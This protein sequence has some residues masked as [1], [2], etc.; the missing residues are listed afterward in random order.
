MGGLGNACRGGRSPPLLI[1]ALIACV[2]V[3]GFNYWVSSAHNLELQKR[4]YEM[5]GA[6]RRAAVERGAVEQKKNDFQEELRRQSDQIDRMETMHKSQLENTLA[7]WKQEKATLLFNISSNSR[8]ILSMKAQFSSLFAS[9]GKIQKELQ[10]CQTNQTK[11]SSDMTQ[12]KAQ[13]V[14]LKKECAEEAVAKLEKIPPVT[15]PSQANAAPTPSSGLGKDG[16][17]KLSQ[18]DTKKPS[19]LASKTGPVAT[20]PDDP[21]AKLPML[22]TNEIAVARDG[23]APPSLTGK[24]LTKLEHSV[25]VATRK[26][27]TLQQEGGKGGAKLRE[28]LEVLD[29]HGGVLQ[30]EGKGQNPG[31]EYN[32]GEQ[33]VGESKAKKTAQL[34]DGTGKGQGLGQAEQDLEDDIADYNGD[35]ENVGE[36]EA[37]K[38]AELAKI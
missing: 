29:T 5:E 2:I 36:F 17:E 9:L 37:D 28:E 35:E 12:C 6:V 22:E 25:P 33:N 18:D 38:Q 16:T 26:I 10:D 3:L 15:P 31:D 24:D 7:K 27:S 32:E 21:N 23:D 19:V 4:L 30:A 1:G 11:L 14:V 13:L 8:T 20:Q 34:T